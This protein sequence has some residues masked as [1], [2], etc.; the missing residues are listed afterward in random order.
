MDHS[1]VAP[2]D[3]PV[4]V[5]RE[6]LQTVSDASNPEDVE[7]LDTNG[8]TA[9]TN[10]GVVVDVFADE[11]HAQI[12]YKTMGWWNVALLM[13][14]ETIS[15]GVLSLP[16]ALATLGLVPGLFLIFFLG[17]LATYTGYVIGQFKIAYPG[18]KDM[19]DAGFILGGK[20]GRELLGAGQVIV[21]VF[22]MAAHITSFSIMMNVVAGHKTC[23]IVFGFVGFVVS[24]G[25]G[26]FRTLHKVSYLSVVSCISVVVAVLVA[27]IA[28]ARSPPNVGAVK[29]V[30]KT[31]LAK[32][33]IAVLNILISYA[34]H[35]AYFGFTAELK[36]PK[37]FPKALVFLNSVSTSFYLVVATV[38]YY[39]AGPGVPAPALSAAG[40]LARKIAYGLA[41]PT[42]VIAGV[43]NGSVAC[44]YIY[45]RYWSGT[46][47][48]HQK[49]F[50]SLGS[51]FLICL[52]LWA[53]AFLLAEAIPS[54]SQLLALVTA[55]FCG[56]FSYGLTGLFWLSINRGRYLEN[57][58][59]MS[60][61]V[62]NVA[63]F[64]L[65]CV[66]CGLGLYASGTAIKNGDTGS[67]FSCADNALT[68]NSGQ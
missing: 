38:I 13:L 2:P 1:Q 11:D 43:V 40:P 47:V 27:M 66:I 37:D 49:S 14:A 68:V 65:G 29:L 20:I 54:F 24:L 6:S 67:P 62:L 56:W 3:P 50:K 51:W 26:L 48:I 12:H 35:V 41:T 9:A 7:K 21:L 52:I 57:W 39:F 4:P 64:C 33:M 10:Y 45:V 42:I 19:A 53:L 17:V 59:K 34:G 32:G 44:K 16:T 60:L 18:V 36:N 23:S 22:I 55:L 58:R 63:I 15:L 5:K 31:T 30:E 28:V 61:T 46:N 8:S 25:L